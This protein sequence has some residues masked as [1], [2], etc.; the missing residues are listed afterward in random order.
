MGQGKIETVQSMC[1]W[2][3]MEGRIRAQWQCTVPVVPDSL[4][5]IWVVSDMSGNVPRA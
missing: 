2:N 1:R 4:S 3:G 5:A